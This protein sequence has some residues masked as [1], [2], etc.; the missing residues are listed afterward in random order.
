MRKE[1]EEKGNEQKRILQNINNNA[2]DVVR[3]KV[4]Q[5]TSVVVSTICSSWNGLLSSSHQVPSLLQDHPTA[6]SPPSARIVLSNLQWPVV[7]LKHMMPRLCGSATK[8]SNQ[9]DM[10]PYCL[11]NP[12]RSTPYL[13]LSA[14]ESVVYNSGSEMIFVEITTSVVV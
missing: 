5:N 13:F 4:F 3:H 11:S 6:S 2:D 9:E 8:K 14:S 12:I 1:R 7:F 10:L